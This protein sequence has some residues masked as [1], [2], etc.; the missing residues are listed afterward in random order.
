MNVVIS[1]PSRKGFAPLALRARN[2]AEKALA[3][4]HYKNSVLELYLVTD[5][6]IKAL[7]K[8]FRGKDEL[9]NVL[10]FEARAFPRGDIGGSKRY[11]GEVY[12][13][14]NVI[15]KRDESI[16][17]LIVHGALHLSGYT[18]AKQSDRIDMEKKEDE[19]LTYVKHH[20]GA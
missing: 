13:A 17:L 1:I 3:C 14:P 12:L 19:I 11:L 2:I 20:H 9:T 10:S 8:L 16:S 7:N 5:I 18:H 4:L 15:K 6:E